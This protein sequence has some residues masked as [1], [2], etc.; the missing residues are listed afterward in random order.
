LVAIAIAGIV[1]ARRRPSAPAPSVTQ[2][3]AAEMTAEAPSAPTSGPQPAKPDTG[4][5]GLQFSE[6]SD[7]LPSDAEDKLSHF[8][9]LAKARKRGLYVAAIVAS[10]ERRDPDMAMARKRLEAIRRVLLIKG[11]NPDDVHPQITQV[12]AGLITRARGDRIELL[13]Q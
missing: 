9:D 2:E 5:S 10:G 12:G 8:A 3:S 7:S 13:I 4:S 1:L 6:S 11:M